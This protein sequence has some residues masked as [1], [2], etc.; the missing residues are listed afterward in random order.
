VIVSS[1]RL[2]LEIAEPGAVYR[3]SR[4]DW[5]G[6]VT[7]VTLDGRHT[8]CGAEPPSGT[9]GLGLHNEFGLLAAI[10]YDEA[11]AGEQFPKLGAGLL[12]RPDDGP[13]QF[14]RP[15][16]IEPFTVSVLQTERAAEFI[17]EPRECR[18]YAA[19][20]VKRLSADGNTLRI[21]YRL[22]NVGV[23]PLET[24]EYVH[25]FLCLGGQPVGPS[26]RLSVPTANLDWLMP[27]LRADGTQVTWTR[28]PGEAFY[29]RTSAL[30]GAASCWE[31]SCGGLTV[32]ECT[33][34]SW[35]SFA[36]WGA[37]TVVS[38][39]AFVAVRVP[40]GGRMTWER[41]Y[42]FTTASIP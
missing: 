12:T 24:S 19:R 27:P 5:T 15:H 28:T 39:E 18:G 25:N 17:V 10:G 37:A 36:L 2:T 22:D 16:E 38:P 31:L 3:G 26:Y 7:Q 30:A 33:D 40:P 9:G 42:T 4:F 32:R 6:T 23:K 29:G 1:D 34:R 14:A 8:F 11:A 35:D 20:L 13:Y 21:G 41:V